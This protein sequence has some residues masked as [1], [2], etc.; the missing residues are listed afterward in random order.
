MMVLGKLKEF[1]MNNNV[2]TV[3]LLLAILGLL[4]S[5]VFYKYTEVKSLERN[6]E[7]AIVKG[8]DPIT[9]RCAYAV[10][11]DLI[12]VAYAASHQSPQIS[13]KSGK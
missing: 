1:V 4:F 9:V 11:N 13:S 8:I 3:S 7:S 5:L 2:F 12:C 10:S 6:I